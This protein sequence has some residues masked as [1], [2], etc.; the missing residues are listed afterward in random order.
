MLM[1]QTRPAPLP[2]K[3]DVTLPGGWSYFGCVDES[4][5]QRLLQG[6]GFT[7]TSMTPT[8]CLDTCHKG[9]FTIAGTEYGDEVS[10]LSC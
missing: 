10:R 5:Y 1:I 7:S 3:R 2:E 9:G 6:L 8:L 4:S